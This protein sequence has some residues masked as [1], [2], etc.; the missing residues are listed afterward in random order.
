MIMM[1]TNI[2]SCQSK[3][4]GTFDAEYNSVSYNLIA[5]EKEHLNV[6]SC[7]ESMQ[8]GLTPKTVLSKPSPNLSYE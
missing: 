8:N 4:I 7:P 5:A 3:I 1:I 6:S 2:C